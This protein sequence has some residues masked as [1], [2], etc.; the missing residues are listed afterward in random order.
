MP[1][2][3]GQGS[4]CTVG[5]NH[6]YES[7]CGVSVPWE[8]VPVNKRHKPGPVTLPNMEREGVKVMRYGCVGKGR[9]GQERGEEE[10]KRRKCDGGRIA[11]E[12]L[13][14]A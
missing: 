4:A 5:V 10:Y 6:C 2:C 3:R 11:S 14:C 1:C 9:G 8:A 12:R 7:K 13:S